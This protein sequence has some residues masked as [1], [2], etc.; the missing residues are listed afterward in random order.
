MANHTRKNGPPDPDWDEILNRL[1]GHEMR[2]I[3]L[4]SDKGSLALQ[5][6]DKWFRIQGAGSRYEFA[7]DDAGAIDDWTFN[8]V[9]ILRCSQLSKPGETP[10]VG[11]YEGRILLGSSHID[12]SATRTTDSVP[13][14]GFRFKLTK[15]KRQSK[16][17]SEK[18]AALP[19]RV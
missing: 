11:R 16:P 12:F 15:E 8:G 17:A 14:E 5:F 10:V 2:G 13:S 6:G 18:K 1:K 19:F 4:P 9:E 3:E 7:A